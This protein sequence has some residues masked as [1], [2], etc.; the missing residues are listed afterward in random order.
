M[1][2]RRVGLTTRLAFV[3]IASALVPFSV[4]VGVLAFLPDDVTARGADQDL[5]RTLALASARAQEHRADLAFALARVDDTELEAVA[6]RR[7]LGP[8]TST[9]RA[10]WNEM[11]IDGP[12]L[13]IQLVPPG[14][15]VVA[16]DPI[17][18]SIRIRP[19]AGAA[20][21]T[22]VVSQPGAT[23]RILR[24]VVDR[25]DLS[26]ALVEPAREVSAIG[27]DRAVDEP[28][29]VRVDADGGVEFATDAPRRWRVQ[30]FEDTAGTWFVAALDGSK[31]DLLLR[32]RG[33]EFRIALVLLLAAGLLCAVTT[34]LLMNR[35]LGRIAATAEHM[36]SG[37]FEE[38]LDVIGTDAAARV[39]TSLNELAEQLQ[40]RIGSLE[41]T[42]D[43]LDRTLAAIDDGVCT[44]SA[45]GR[46]ETW[47]AAAATLIGTTADEARAGAP[48]T[49]AL[50]AGR[51]PGR[52]RV[53]L[54]L[55]DGESHVVTDL[56]VR[57]MQD[58]GTLQVFRDAA[59]ALSL[60]QA[61]A[62]F[63]V[64]AAHELRTPLTSILGFAATLADDDLH[65]SDD[66]HAAAMGH[67]LAG[68]RR[69]ADV[70]Q[71]LFD[72]SLLV[73]DRIEVALEPV[74]LLDVLEHVVQDSIAPMV[75]FVGVSRGV[76]VRADR[77]ALERAL[78]AIL[79]NAA[80]YGEPPIEVE[81]V[82][83]PHDERIEVV[84]RDYGAGVPADLVDTV[85]EPF[86]RLDPEMRSD[87][88]GAGM[89]LYNARRLLGAMDASVVARTAQGRGSAPSCTEFVVVVP[90][91]FA[92][93]GAARVAA[94]S[95]VLPVHVP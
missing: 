83:H 88:G 51:T 55:A 47:N 64:T 11:A 45:D 67:V 92:G 36:S 69:L 65:I 61:R 30:A 72:T 44:W 50:R 80:K 86:H 24:D 40:L 35:L 21:W 1:R 54:P 42:V 6:R 90:R 8:A 3:G 9:I 62:N 29:A 85:F 53:L 68:A 14:A 87:V 95:A 25:T 20:Q 46:L 22:V 82:D 33:Q 48:V 84:V 79:D 16:R 19:R 2:G 38:R 32:G 77:A 57:R 81:V 52:R 58:G 17:T 26:I 13:A 7:A 71:S 37:D 27:G 63:L 18:T 89:G 15:P 5:Q 31:F 66:D 12:Q 34:A 49:E 75:E 73:R 70:V 94:S 78:A 60:E 10:A 43:R 91:W 4:A 76:T 59:P 39:A 28:W 41:G 74:D 56:Y 23:R 93:E